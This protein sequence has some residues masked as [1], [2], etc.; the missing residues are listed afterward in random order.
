MKKQHAILAL[1]MALVF[2]FAYVGCAASN[3]SSGADRMPMTYAATTAGAYYKDTAEE[4]AMTVQLAGGS[5]STLYTPADDRMVIK[6]A[7]IEVETLDYAASVAAFEQTVAKYGGYISSSSTGGNAEYYSRYMEVEVRIPAENLEAFLGDQETVGN[8]TGT[9][10]WVEDV[11]SQYV[12]N[13]AR[14]E[15]LTTKKERLLDILEKAT[16]LTDIIEL[17][18][19]LSDTIYQLELVTGS[20][21]QLVD[22]ITYSTV[23]LHLWETV[24]LSD[25][26]TTPIT[27]GERISYNFQDSLESVKE[28]FE[29]LIVFLA[30][31]SPVLVLLLVIAG[32][33]FILVWKGAKRSQRKRMERLETYNRIKAQQNT[34]QAQNA[35]DETNIE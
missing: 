28:F 22:R 7:R 6:N 10:I 23:N 25:T 21:N 9:H 27:L 5:G 13:A 8:V 3:E 12:D 31:N 11:T 35:S 1:I 18:T 20:Q 2:V 19:A 17:E 26:R 24:D 33:I 34:A 4:S 32:V 16:N 15:S 29:D 30:G 14:I